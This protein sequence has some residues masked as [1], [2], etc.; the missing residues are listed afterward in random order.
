MQDYMHR[1]P[2]VVAH[3]ICESLGYATPSCAAGILKDAHEDRENW[4]EWVYS[5][6][7]RDP[8]VPVLN[9]IRHRHTHHGYMAEYMLARALVQR[10]IETGDEPIFASWF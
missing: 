2:R 8:Q 4:C 9:A 5:C 10:A 7:N 1:Y 6:Y 3:I